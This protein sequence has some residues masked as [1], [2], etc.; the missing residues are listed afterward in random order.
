MGDGSATSG[1][2]KKSVQFF[3]PKKLGKATRPLYDKGRQ[4]PG[5]EGVSIKKRG[6]PLIFLLIFVDFCGILCVFV[7]VF[8]L[9]ERLRQESS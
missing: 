2:G 7:Y 6:N 3:F 1:Q 8:Y 5:R 9:A 4:R